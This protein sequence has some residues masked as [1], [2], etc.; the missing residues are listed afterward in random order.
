[1]AT[2]QTQPGSD[3]LSAT[4]ESTLAVNAS[5]ETH[6]AKLLQLVRTPV[7]PNCIEITPVFVGIAG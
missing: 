6:K 7:T 2:A 4:C 1:M 5:R 3:F